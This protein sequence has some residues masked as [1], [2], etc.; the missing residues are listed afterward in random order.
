[1]VD[2]ELLPY[3]ECLE[4]ITDDDLYVL[5][6]YSEWEVLDFSNLHTCDLEYIISMWR[7]SKRGFIRSRES[8]YRITLRGLWFLFINRPII[9]IGK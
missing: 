3:D 7:L 5:R 2:D 8:T 9:L 4:V 6:G 1:M